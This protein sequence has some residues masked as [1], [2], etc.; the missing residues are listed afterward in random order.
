[1]SRK[2]KFNGI[3][4]C[5]WHIITHRRRKPGFSLHQ[6]P[7]SPVTVGFV[8]P[9]L[10]GIVR[11][12]KQTR[13]YLTRPPR[14]FRLS[15]RPP[16]PL[17]SLRPKAINN[18]RH[19]CR[20]RCSSLHTVC[21]LVCTFYFTD[22]LPGFAQALL[23]SDI[24]AQRYSR[25][26]GSSTRHA[27]WSI[28]SMLPCLLNRSWSAQWRANGQPLVSY[29]IDFVFFPPIVQFDIHQRGTR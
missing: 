10:I 6:L 25:P 5:Q 8:I 28:G 27:V 20:R 29:F 22:T 18:H 26:A 7:C 24:H 2:V 17:T 1:M 3:G 23:R 13:T 16:S 15:L 12:R 11:R 14:P 9:K 21:H 4:D 19:D